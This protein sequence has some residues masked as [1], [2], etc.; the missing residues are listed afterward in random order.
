MNYGKL[1]PLELWAELGAAVLELDT[2]AGII[3]RQ[4]EALK[5]AQFQLRSSTANW[6]E[7]CYF[8]CDE[9]L[10]AALGQEQK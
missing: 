6:H 2:L 9:I 5:A 7:D 1:T 4:R 10:S 8:K 3:E